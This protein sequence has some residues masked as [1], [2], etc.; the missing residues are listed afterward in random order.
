MGTNFPYGVTA[1]DLR[2]LERRRANLDRALSLKK[3][4]RARELARFDD[5]IA[6]IET[7]L[8]DTIEELREKTEEWENQR[9][10]N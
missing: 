3:Q 9:S 10:N 5:M 8:A 6:T 1:E 4:M 2:R 7:D